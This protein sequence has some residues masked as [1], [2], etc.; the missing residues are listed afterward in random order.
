MNE[1]TRILGAH[2]YGFILDP[3]GFDKC[4]QKHLPFTEGLTPEEISDLEWSQ[5]EFAMN[6]IVETCILTWWPR[7]RIQVGWNATGRHFILA[8]VA[9]TTPDDKLLPPPETV[10]NV[11]KFLTEEGFDTTPPEWFIRAQFAKFATEDEWYEARDAW[12]AATRRVVLPEPGV[13]EPLVESDADVGRVVDLAKEY[14]DIGVQV[15]VKLA[16][17]HLT[18]E[19]PT[20][21]GGAWHVEGKRVSSLSFVLSRALSHVLKMQNEHICASAVYYYDSENIPN[22]VFL[23]RDFAIFG[24]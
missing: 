3:E 12:Y 16:N 5:S 6:H 4:G 19:K 15:I 7:S 1:A 23:D 14:N 22:P 17:I 8:L 2:F 18:P 11:R 20:Y 24:V 13:F 9:S 10:D 21:E